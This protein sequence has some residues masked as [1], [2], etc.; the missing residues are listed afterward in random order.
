MRDGFWTLPKR[1]KMRTQFSAK[2]NRH[3]GPH[4]ARLVS[5]QKLRVSRL[6][7]SPADVLR[8]A[9]MRFL[10]RGD[11]YTDPCRG[12]VPYCLYLKC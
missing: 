5:L 11:L 1:S 10:N 9:R 3:T 12:R 4:Y 6:H 8:L 2:P 7:S